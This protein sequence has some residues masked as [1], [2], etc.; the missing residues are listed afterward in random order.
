M[1]SSALSF[2][3]LKFW[4]ALRD[5]LT[6]VWRQIFCHWSWL[7]EWLWNRGVRWLTTDR[8]GEQVRSPINFTHLLQEVR[9]GD[10]LLVS[11]GT[12][13]SHAISMI[14]KSPWTHAALVIG[15]LA[16]Q[17]DP[18]LRSIIRKQLPADADLNGPLIVESELGCGTTVSSLMRYEHAD[19]RICR[20]A[21]LSENDARRVVVYGVLHLGVDYNV[22]QILDLARF[23]VPWWVGIPR[24]WHSSLFEH[25]YQAA[26]SVIC[27]TMIARAFDRIRFPIRPLIVQEQQRFVLHRRNSKL[28]TPRD[29]DYSPYFEIIKYPLFSEDDIEFYRTLPWTDQG[30]AEEAVAELLDSHDV[31]HIKIKSKTTAS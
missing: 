2:R 7:G 28:V 6:Q 9:P 14:T 19:V 31:M 25:N 23:M 3:V 5:E 8:R 12:R 26:T 29:F 13:L 30:L 24:R 1:M 10:V 15:T 21:G 17:R 22:R 20:P 18:A 16:Q 4:N 11:G 27:S